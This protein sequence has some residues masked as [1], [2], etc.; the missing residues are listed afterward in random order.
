M[1]TLNTRVFTLASSLVALL[2]AA[3]ASAHISLDQMGTHKSRYGDEQKFAPC[4]RQNGTKGTNIYTYKPGE[5]I[6]VEFREY[7]PHPGYYRFAF[8]DD[9]DD[10][11]VSPLSIK[12][13]DPARPCPFNAT[14][15]CGESDFYNSDTVLPGMDNLEPHLAGQS[16][17]TYSFQ[18][19]LPN[20]QCENCTLQLLQVMEDTIHG[21]YNTDPNEGSLPDVYY[22]CIDIKLVGPLEGA[23]G[24]AGAAPAAEDDGGCSVSSRQASGAAGL[25]IALGLVGALGRRRRR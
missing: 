25:M 4:G 1:A 24:T 2:T 10:D 21:A 13:V 23:G 17:G 16:K 9:G 14:D 22:Q 20:V 8:D 19:K 12:P 5:T 11:F 6:T 18:V 15:M 7:I 3:S